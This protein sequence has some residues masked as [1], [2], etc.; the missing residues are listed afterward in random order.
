MDGLAFTKTLKNDPRL[1]NIPIIML[2]AK[3][4]ESD[5]VAGLELGAD[6]ILP[7][8]SAPGS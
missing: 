8:L 4:E 5:I 3:G 6:D 1:R 7:S 2:T